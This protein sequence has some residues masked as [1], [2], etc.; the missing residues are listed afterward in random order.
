[1]LYDLKIDVDN[2]RSL[3]EYNTGQTKLA[4]QTA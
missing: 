4:D 2:Y 1:M 3:I